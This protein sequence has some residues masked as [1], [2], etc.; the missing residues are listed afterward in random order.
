MADELI[1]QVWKTIG[2]LDEPDSEGL[3]RIMEVASSNDFLETIPAG[4]VEIGKL[5]DL[6]DIQACE[7]RVCSG[8]KLCELAVK[9]LQETGL[10][11]SCGRGKYRL[12]ERYRPLDLQTK[13]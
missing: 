1:A 12:D 5:C 11:M 4:E 3:S 9:R 8:P 6:L 13:E 7:K 10:L 2:D